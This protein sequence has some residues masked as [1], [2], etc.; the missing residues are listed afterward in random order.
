MSAATTSPR[1]GRG[2]PLVVL[3][4]LL[5]GWT[6]ARVAAWSGDDPLS[7]PAAVLTVGT[8]TAAQAESGG[9]L[10]LPGP[11]SFAGAGFAPPPYWGPYGRPQAPRVQLVPV[12][13]GYPPA[14]YATLREGA[15]PGY[16]ARVPDLALAG[17]FPLDGPIAPYRPAEPMPTALYPTSDPPPVR[18]G[19]PAALLGGRLGR[20]AGDRSRWSMDAWALLRDDGNKPLDTGTLPATYGASQAGAVLRYRLAMQDRHKPT[21]YLRATKALGALDELAAALGVSARPLASVPII[22]AIEGRLV[23][24]NGTR[25]L[26]PAV[27]AVT[28]VPPLP[29]PGGLQAEIYG[30]AGYVG[31]GFSTPFADGQAR[32]DHGLLA[33]GRYEARVGGGVWGGIQKGASRV[34]AGPTATLSLPL[35]PKVFGR[36]AVDWRFRVAGNAEPD[37]GPALTLAAGF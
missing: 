9:M 30:Q 24:Q 36:V 35:A 25:R 3:G 15:L 6:G 10:P 11:Q 23:D 31:G 2:Q 19:E 37:S 18:Y 29:L 8:A 14:A 16:A 32:V 5:L 21:A 27:M 20:L 26:Q 34:D 12:W 7:L 28:E 13:R 1:R 22:A 4:A 33:A 17:G